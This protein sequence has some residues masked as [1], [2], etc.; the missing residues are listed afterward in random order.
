MHRTPEKDCYFGMSQDQPSIRWMPS[1]YKR[2]SLRPYI[3]QY[4]W[5]NI[6]HR[7][8]FDNLTARQAEVLENWFIKKAKLD[9]FCI[10]KK[11]SGGVYR[12][13]PKEYQRERKRKYRQT[14]ECKAYM[15]EYR[16]R[17]E[18]KEKQREYQRQYRLKK[19]SLNLS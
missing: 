15:R 3:I 8:L 4:G 9:G 16:Q 19:K 7:V 6:E 5:D 17:P 11:E 13:H 18:N 12:D 2:T 14:E 1:S 10:N